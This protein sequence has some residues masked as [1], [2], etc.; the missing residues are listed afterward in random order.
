MKQAIAL[1]TVGVMSFSASSFAHDNTDFSG[2]RIGGGYS[3][4]H[5][6]TAQDDHIETGHYGDGFKVEA[7][8]DF[9][10]IVGINLAYQEN[11]GSNNLSGS[12]WK[13]DTDIGYAF[14]FSQWQLKPYA[15]VGIASYKEDYT[16]NNRNLSNDDTSILLGAGVR[17]TL[18][19]GFY[20]NF[21][22]DFMLLKDRTED[23][24]MGQTSLTFGYQF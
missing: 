23:V 11:N 22:Q 6:L 7:G 8:Y 1:L 16:I 13:L 19:G 18:E 9:N 24:S 10:H 17:F 21:K 12:T 14:D 2:F 5:L 3:T 15:A 20:A 4:T